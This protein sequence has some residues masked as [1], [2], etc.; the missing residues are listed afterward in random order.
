MKIT[1]YSYYYSNENGSIQF[2]TYGSTKI[3]NK[4]L[5]ECDKLLSELV[6]LN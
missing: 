2:I 5:K 3:I 4:N 6:E 1:Y